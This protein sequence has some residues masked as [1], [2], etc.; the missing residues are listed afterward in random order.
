MD[1]RPYGEEDLGALAQLWL[2]GWQ[3]TGLSVASPATLEELRE[4][5]PRELC[6]GWCVFLAHS[7]ADLLGFVALREDDHCLDQLFVAPSCQRR[8]IGRCLLDFAKGRMPTGFWLRTAVA[9]T[10]ACRFYE[11]EGFVRGS[12]A[13]HPRHGHPTVIY[14]WSLETTQDDRGGARAMTGLE[15]QYKDS[16]NLEARAAIYRFATGP[17]LGPREVLDLMLATIPADADV[18]EVGCGPGW[19]WR[20]NLARVP[21]SWRVLLTDLMPGMACEAA[22]GLGSDAR[23]RVRRMDVQALDL[24]DAGFDAV[25]ASWMLYH[26]PDRPRAV[27]EIRR[28]LKPGG[29]LFAATNGEAHVGEIDAL[30]NEYLGEASP[31]RSRLAFSLENGMGQLGPFFDGIVVHEKRSS[32]R[33]TEPEAVVRYVLSFDAAKARIV[34][35]RLEEL[36]GRVQHEIQSAG[37]F[38]VQTRSGLFIARKA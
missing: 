3:S 38:V 19:M 2:E 33:I 29:A 20:S 37:A 7:K 8:G 22:A 15:T 24:P 36:R 30:V 23:F 13:P 18:L 28:V 6:G 10:R 14:R 32:L 16:S 4:R 9:N 25:I 31:V 21:R 12:M 17:G 27:A 1:I 11:R 5:I 35:D 26:V 34:G